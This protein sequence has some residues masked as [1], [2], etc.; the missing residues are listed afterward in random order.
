MLRNAQH[1]LQANFYPLTH[2]IL[3]PQASTKILM[4]TLTTF[5]KAALLGFTIPP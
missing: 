2:A 5:A 4:D 1:V 3:A